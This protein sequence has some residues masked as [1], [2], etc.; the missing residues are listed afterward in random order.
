MPSGLQS[1][2]LADEN[3][4][5]SRAFRRRTDWKQGAGPKYR[6]ELMNSPKKDLHVFA[7]G[8]GEL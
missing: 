7:V 3:L 5:F 1:L 4:L 8:L 6:Y 2:D